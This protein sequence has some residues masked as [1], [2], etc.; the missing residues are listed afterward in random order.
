MMIDL[1]APVSP[2]MAAK[3]GASS[4]SRSSTSARFLIRSK[5]STAAMREEVEVVS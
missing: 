1:P 5:L 2:V 3:P 4:H